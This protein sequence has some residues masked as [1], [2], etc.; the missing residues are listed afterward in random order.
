MKRKKK[1]E[2]K[3]NFSGNETLAK[4]RNLSLNILASKQT[5]K[6]AAEKSC[7]FFRDRAL[8]LIS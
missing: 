7:R 1:K 4:R 2:T 3:H 6:Q 8:K 5:S